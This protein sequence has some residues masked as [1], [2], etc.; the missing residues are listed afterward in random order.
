MARDRKKR[1]PGKKWILFVAFRFL[2]SRRKERKIR[3]SFFSILGLAVGVMT[4]L[5]VLAVMNGFQL[6]FIEDILEIGSYHIRIYQQEDEDQTALLTLLR[7]MPEVEAAVPFLDVQTMIEG[8]FS[9][10]VGCNIRALPEDTPAI[11]P[12][13]ARQMDLD[14][15][16]VT[17][18]ER[19]LIK[20]GSVWIGSVLAQN[21]GIT[22][23]DSVSFLSMAGDSFRGLEPTKVEYTV[24]LIFSSGYYEYDSALAFVAHDSISAIASGKEKI[25]IGVKLKN[26]W[27]DRQFIEELSETGKLLPGTEVVSWR[28]YNRSFFGALRMEKLAMM[29]VIGIVFIVVGANMKHSLERTVWEKKEEIGL[30]RSVGAHP[31]DIRLIFLLDGALIGSIGGGIGTALGL[32]IAENI[33]GIFSLTEKIVNAVIAFTER[34]LMPF[35]QVRGETFS[36]FSSTY[37]YLQEIPSRVM[38]H[39]V[40]IVFL[41]AL[42]ASLLSA[43][44]S[45]GRVADFD[46]AE[47]MR[48][49]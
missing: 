46:P 41:F 38:Y 34:L 21:L 25:N 43:W 23:G 10:M 40:L 13:W 1:L 9:G 18:G 16:F 47:I 31:R 29:L 11:D 2:R 6:G 35:F 19:D 15:A 4:L 28:Q 37:F 8:P 14:D 22:T 36:L 24:S 48:Y 17:D 3:P 45:S 7:G 20:P 5:S 12:G 27:R 42:A 26:R 32:L 39:E 30:L 33:N 49:E 44:V